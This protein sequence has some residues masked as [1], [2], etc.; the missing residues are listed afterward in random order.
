VSTAL[1]IVTVALLALLFAALLAALALHRRRDEDVQADVWSHLEE[2]RRRLLRPAAVLVAGILV[3]LTFRID[4]HAGWPYPVPALFDNL[5][6]QLFQAAARDLVPPQVPLIVTSPLDGFGAHMAMATGLAFSVTLPVLLYQLGRFVGPALRPRE[7]RL[8]ALALV[9]AM[10]LFLLGAAFAYALVLPAT[11]AALYQF[12]ESLGAQGLLQV[13]EFASFTLAFLVGFGVAF[14]LPVVM[15]VLSRVGL[16]H[17]RAYWRKWRHAVV[18][19]LV[20][21]MVVTPDP[22]IFS[23]LMLALPLIGLYVLGAA[24]ATRVYPN[25]SV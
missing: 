23:Q 24:V 10:A 9:P 1:R 5:A 7:R 8:I 20:V 21:G 16:V 12:S 15:V 4:M 2:L 19:M 25:E 13:G 11:L 6:S 3:A 17:P 14:Q 18:L 22:T